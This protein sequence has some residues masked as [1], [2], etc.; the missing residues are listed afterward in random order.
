MHHPISHTKVPPSAR[1]RNTR[2]TSSPAYDLTKAVPI[3]T[4]PN[5]VIIAASHTEPNRFRARLEGMSTAIYYVECSTYM[6]E[7]RGKTTY[8][9][10]KYCKGNIVIE[11]LHSKIF[12]D[13]F[14]L[15]S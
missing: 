9:E 11:T 4:I 14:R 7:S 10:I 13:S 6:Q 12:L 3:E 1:P 8:E 15:T 5:E 2:I